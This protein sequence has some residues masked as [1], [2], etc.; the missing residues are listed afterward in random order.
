MTGRR[1]RLAKLEARAKKQDALKAGGRFDADPVAGVWREA[2]GGQGRTF[3][4]SPEDLPEGESVG[5]LYLGPDG[6]AKVYAGVTWG[7]L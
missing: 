6:S 2:E 4:F 1:G 3:P 5:A 7:D